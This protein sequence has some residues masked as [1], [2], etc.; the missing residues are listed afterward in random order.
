MQHEFWRKEGEEE[1]EGEGRADREKIGRSEEMERKGSQHREIK[2]ITRGHLQ[3]YPVPRW[4]SK[5]QKKQQ[6]Q[7]QTTTT[8]NNNNKTHRSVLSS[9]P[10][11]SD[12]SPKPNKALYTGSCSLR[13]RRKKNKSISTPAKRSSKEKI[14]RC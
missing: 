10:S 5:N 1:G 6:Q 7:Q 9:S 11:K 3:G 12:N 2:M 14:H 8:N 13:R 4:C